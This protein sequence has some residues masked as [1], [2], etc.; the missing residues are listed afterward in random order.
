MGKS[1]AGK[2]Q[3]K[4]LEPTYQDYGYPCYAV[5]N[6]FT[7]RRVYF[8]VKKHGGKQKAK[9]A[10]LAFISEL[11]AKPVVPGLIRS[12]RSPDGLPRGIA[13]HVGV[14]LR[15]CQE[16]YSEVHSVGLSVEAGSYGELKP[17]SAAI[18]KR[19]FDSAFNLITEEY[20]RR[21]SLSKSECR[22]VLELREAVRAK[23]LKK[24]RRKCREIGFRPRA[25]IVNQIKETA[26]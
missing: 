26:K 6:R 16:G 25:D 8:P 4:K 24:Y 5:Y 7:S 17:K 20:F 13:M 18:L 22:E 2:A 14:Y 9:Q 1:A 3:H 10:A 23:L 15:K 11:N 12:A 19:G 21:L